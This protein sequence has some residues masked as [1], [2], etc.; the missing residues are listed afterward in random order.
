M[1]VWMFQDPIYTVAFLLVASLGTVEPEVEFSLFYP[2]R[3]N[4]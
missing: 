3:A 1:K 2:V 4:R